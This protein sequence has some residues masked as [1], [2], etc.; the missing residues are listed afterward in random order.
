LNRFVWCTEEEEESVFNVKF[1]GRRRICK[2]EPEDDNIPKFCGITDFDSSPGKIPNLTAIFILFK[3][4][5]KP[6]D[7]T[8]KKF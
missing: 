2:A 4:I 1:D 7:E 3:L 8:A 5:N 6:Q